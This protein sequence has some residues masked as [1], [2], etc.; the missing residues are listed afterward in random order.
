MALVRPTGTGLIRPTGT[1]LIRPTGTGLVRTAANPSVVTYQ[2]VVLADN[3]A[4]FWRLDETSGATAADSSGN[5]TTLNYAGTFTVN[6]APLI[7]AGRAALLNSGTARKL[8]STAIFNANGKVTLEAWVKTTTAVNGEI[9]CSDDTTGSRY[10]Q[11]IIDGAG[12][13]T[14]TLF[15][16][17][18]GTHARTGAIAVNDN[19]RHH[20]VATYDGATIRLY[21]D[22]AEDGTGTAA[23]FTL[24]T[25]NSNICIGERFSG[26]ADSNF[27]V[28][29][30]DEVAIYTSALS[31][32][33]VLAHY[34]AGIT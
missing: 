22:G 25:A 32:A 29:T 30:F 15:D 12:H 14:V 10:F 9:I 3:P 19:L 7:T 2:S 27:L 23:V 1:G 24:A 17:A 4:G 33:R 6:Q 28:G 16:T 20:L 8:T 11:W 31:A 34:N 5:G 13:M 18:V 21:V 26:G